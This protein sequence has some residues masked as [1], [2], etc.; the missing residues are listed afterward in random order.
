M[1]TPYLVFATLDWAVCLGKMSYPI[2]RT[3]VVPTLEEDL[4]VLFSPQN[5][6]ESD[7]NKAVP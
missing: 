7:K 2:L 4:F 1:S 5:E 3:M 6:S